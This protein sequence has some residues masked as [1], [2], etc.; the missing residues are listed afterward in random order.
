VDPFELP[1]ELPT[2]ADA[3]AA[4]LADAEQWFTSLR[5]IVEAGDDVSDD[6]LASLRQ[7]VADIETIESAQ[8]EIETASQARRDEAAQLIARTT[9]EPENEPTEGEP[10]EGESTEGESTEGE[11]TESEPDETNVLEGEVLEAPLAASAGARRRSTRFAGQGK[12]RTVAVRGSEPDIGWRMDPNMFGY[13]SGYVGFEEIATAVDSIRPNSRPRA[14]RSAPQGNTSFSAQ[15][16]ARLDRK[17]PLIN[18]PHALVAE[19]ERATDETQLPGGSLVAAGG[20]C[21]PSETLYDFCA[22]PQATDLLSLPEITIRRGG[23]RWPVEPDLSAIFDSFEWFFTEPELEAEDAEGNPTAI[24]TCV[25]VPCPDEFE[26]LRLNAVGYCVEVGILQEQGWPELIQWFLQSITAEHFKALSKRT[27]LDMVSQSGTP[28]VIPAD[29]QLGTDSSILNSL[30]LMAT[31]LRLHKGLARNATIEGV[32]PSW[33]HEVIRADL[34]NQQGLDTKSV[35]D[36]QINSQLSA[37]N[38]A[39]QFEGSWQSRETG[40]PGH[41]DTLVWPSTVDVLLY[42]AGTWFRAMSNVIELGA[43]YPRELLQVNRY[44]RFFTEDAIAV[45]KRCN[46]SIVVTV[47]ICPSGASGAPGTVACAAPTP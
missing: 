17:L 10:T 40:Q 3:L 8:N 39:L 19:I 29:S 41:L 34:A 36:A 27:V 47:P 42:P 25:E 5:S 35:T 37:R 23:V 11:S 45:G 20:W 13:K 4:L 28:K 14:S 22:V 31:N 38:L 15:T 32:A 16:I 21:A 7:V 2:T 46:Q 33:T 1:D 43:M 12:G 24:K 26:E 18:D 6:Q 44:T 9:G 30:A